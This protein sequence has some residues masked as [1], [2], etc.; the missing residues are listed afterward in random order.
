MGQSKREPSVEIR[1]FPCEL[2]SFDCS[3]SRP[4]GTVNLFEDAIWD[5]CVGGEGGYNEYEVVFRYDKKLWM[6]NYYIAQD[7]C[8][9]G[10][11]QDYK[12]I[13]AIRVEQSGR[14]Y[15]PSV[16]WR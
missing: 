10:V 13:K 7:D 8:D 5:R 14:K 12:T 11:F 4:E 3:K 6:M 1:E 2:F 9:N 16:S 15:I